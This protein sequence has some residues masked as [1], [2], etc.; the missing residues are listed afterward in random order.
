M[1]NQDIKGNPAKAREKGRLKKGKKHK[2]TLLKEAIGIDNLKTIENQIEANIKEFISSEDPKIRFEATKAF[3]DYYKPKK[4]ELS[5]SLDSQV[6]VTF[7][8]NI[9]E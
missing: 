7:Q 2:S 6:T 1:P 5:G 4:K 9:S 8:D 3:T